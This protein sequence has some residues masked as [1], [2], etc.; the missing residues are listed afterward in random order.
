MI[1][2]ALLVM[3]GFCTAGLLALL[4]APTIWRRAVRLTTKRLDATLPM[5]LSDIEADKDLLR[6]SYA[7]QIRR[8]EAGLNKARDKSASQLV[9]I[10]KLQMVIGEFRDK[11]STLDKQ[12]EERS[13]AANV[14]ERTI[15]KRFPEMEG[16][17]TAAKAALDERSY[18]ITDLG[19]QIRRKEEALSLIQRSSTLQQQEI[20]KLRESIEGSATDKTG[21]F[22]KRPSQWS[23]E[24]FRSEY[25]R[26]NL[27]LS[28]MREQLAL[29]Q[30]RES[31]QV[32]VLRGEL[33]NLAEKIMTAVAAQEKHI[34]EQRTAAAAEAAKAAAAARNQDPS[35]NRRMPAE[36]P[37]TTP[38][39]WRGDR[40]TLRPEAP[41]PEAPKIQEP[42]RPTPH[43][44]AS[45]PATPASRPDTEQA[46]AA[47]PTEPK[48]PSITSEASSA[49]TKPEA[50]S[51]KSLLNRATAAAPME[52][53][54]KETVA[55][56]AVAAA[57]ATPPQPQ[58]Q[59]Q[60]Q[61]VEAAVKEA[62]SIS[63]VRAGI[64]PGESAPVEQAATTKASEPNLD[65]MLREI[66]EGRSPAVSTPETA[67]AAAAE[68]PPAA[69][70]KSAAPSPEP[71]PAV[72]SD[73]ESDDIAGEPEKKQSLLERLRVV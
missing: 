14:F 53:A 11:V 15:K 47:R 72:R 67:P 56:P 63:A 54:V 5:S 27:E 7:V 24:E 66:F 23:L 20:R 50:A 42:V 70:P 40:E 17:L 28:K 9:E 21:R 38:Q 61:T 64:A 55:A 57:Q 19:N 39:P 30:E 10:S 4:I 71:K 44:P 16:A 45:R 32:A 73:A 6:A 29:A 62:G 58:A 34:A 69:E 37:Q 46:S 51:L 33:Q 31:G 59:A 12:L 43:R 49:G 52:P 25:D 60:T 8:L 22:K 41:K 2:Y 13:N 36:R 18:E 65:R 48:R 1:E 3:L 68:T 26:L 35:P